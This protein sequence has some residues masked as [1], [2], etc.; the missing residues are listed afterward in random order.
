MSQR[1]HPIPA[2]LN[3]LLAA[4]VTGL[5]L[6]L[7]WA[8]GRVETWWAVALLALGYGLVMTTGYALCHEAEH[9]ILHPHP[10]VN[11]WTGTLLTLFFPGSFTLRRQGHLGH[12]L[13]NRTDDEAFDVFFAGDRPAWKRLQFYG[14]LT[15]L[16][17]LVIVASN[18]PA[19]LHPAWLKGARAG[20]DRSTAALQE[21]LN[22]RT[23]PR[24]R[25]EAALVFLLHGALIYGFQIPPLR[26]FAV[27]CGFG[28]LWSTLQYVHHY[29][30]PRDIQRG[31]VNLHVWR[32]FD[33][34]W[35]HHHWHLNHHLHPTVPW[36]HLPR[37]T[38]ADTPPQ[39][40]WR[41]YLR[42]WRGPQLTREHLAN[43][44]AGRIIQ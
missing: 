9:D 3:L 5:C 38:G 24:I 25:L 34:L 20:F 39:P 37:L 16:F 6:A 13:R 23:F 15:G 40:F 4:L 43:P 26:W 1:T 28:V 31:A 29:G 32:V 21:T 35:L 30:T 14:I 42:L 2:R 11:D 10:A 8:A 33:L 36:P 12:H 7:L 27:L 22:P 19:L 18:L 17:W 44:H 41:T